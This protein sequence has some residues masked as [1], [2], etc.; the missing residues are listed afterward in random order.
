M[1]TSHRNLI[2]SKNLIGGFFWPTFRL[3]RVGF[4][5]FGSGSGRVWSKSSGFGFGYCAYYDLDANCL[6]ILCYSISC[7]GA[8]LKNKCFVIQIMLRKNWNIITDYRQPCLSSKRTVLFRRNGIQSWRCF[9][10]NLDSAIAK[11]LL[12]KY[13]PTKGETHKSSLVNRFSSYQVQP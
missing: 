13:N 12:C 10:D 4:F 5:D 2:W 6:V 9:G 1:G 8:D 3:W 11:C 7:K